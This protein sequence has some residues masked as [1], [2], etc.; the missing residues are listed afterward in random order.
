MR[1]GPY[2]SNYMKYVYFKLS[3]IVNWRRI[4]M[5]SDGFRRI[6]AEFRNSGQFLW[7]PS[8]FPDSSGFQRNLWRNKKYCHFQSLLDFMHLFP[9]SRTTCLFRL[10]NLWLLSL[11]VLP[12]LY[13]VGLFIWVRSGCRLKIFLAISH[14]PAVA[15]P[16]SHPSEFI[17]SSQLHISLIY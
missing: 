16:S 6:P 3:L 1:Q 14:G 10:G 15:G 2:K 11:I 13:L 8:E 9:S 7:N 5:D 12:L 17:S 4:P